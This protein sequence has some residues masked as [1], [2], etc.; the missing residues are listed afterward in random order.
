MRC[1]VERGCADATPRHFAMA[2]H[3]PQDG[4]VSLLSAESPFRRSGK[5]GLRRNAFGV[6]QTVEEATITGEIEGAHD[7][8]LKLVGERIRAARRRAGLKQSDLA[9]AIGAKQPYIVAV[10]AGENLTLKSLAR[11]SAVL[12]IQPMM[13]LVEGELA[14]AIDGGLFDRI[15]GLVQQATQQ[16]EEIAGILRQLQELVPSQVGQRNNPESA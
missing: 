10:E 16:N 12:G 8:F 4:Q 11:I 9:S 14:A 15:G 6:V 3:T 7:P 13:L 5:G 1:A 2:G